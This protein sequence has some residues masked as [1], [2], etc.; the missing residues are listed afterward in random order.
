[1]QVK[2]TLKHRIEGDNSSLK[3]PINQEIKNSWIV[4]RICKLIIEEEKLY[5]KFYYITMIY[6]CQ[7]KAIL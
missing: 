2:Q 5:L 1:M 7:T 3:I 6:F 4:I